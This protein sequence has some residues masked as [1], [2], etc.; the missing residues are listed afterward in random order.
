MR[1]RLGI[2]LVRGATH[3]SGSRLPPAESAV[4]EGH[5]TR[6]KF[7][8]EAGQFSRVC[9]CGRSGLD[10]SGLRLGPVVRDQRERAR[11]GSAR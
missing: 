6:P 4:A 10:R 5:V 11:L 9:L 8:E 2:A 1:I 3:L 7:P